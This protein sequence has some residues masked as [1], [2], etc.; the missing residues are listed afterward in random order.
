VNTGKRT[1]VEINPYPCAETPVT[2]SGQKS[3][4]LQ[5][6]PRKETQIEQ[7]ETEERNSN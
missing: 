7:I 1:I 3:R 6:K 5:M 4:Q 2:S